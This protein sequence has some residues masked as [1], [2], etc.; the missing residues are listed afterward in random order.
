MWCSRGLCGTHVEVSTG[1]LGN[2]VWGKRK[3]WKQYL[4][5]AM[6]TPSQGTCCWGLRKVLERPYLEE[7]VK[8]KERRLAGRE[9]RN[10]ILREGTAVAK[11]WKL[12]KTEPFYRMV[13]E[14]R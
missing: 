7:A 6:A 4:S 10:S 12:G 9:W 11:A 3:F 8:F 14:G 1:Q 13:W 2:G 5:V